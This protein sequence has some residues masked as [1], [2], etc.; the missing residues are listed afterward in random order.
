MLRETAA[1]KLQYSFV[2]VVVVQW[3]NS[4]A[5]RRFEYEAKS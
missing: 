2:V 5:S 3:G 1:V 4:R